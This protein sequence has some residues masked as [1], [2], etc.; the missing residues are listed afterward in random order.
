MCFKKGVFFIIFCNLL[1]AQEGEAFHAIKQ[2]YNPLYRVNDFDKM[3]FKVD[4]NSD[5]DNF[6]IHTINATNN[7]RNSLMPNQLLKLRLS[8]DYKFLG[9]FFSTSPSFLPGNE[10]NINKG[11]TKTL[12]LSFKFFF[13]DRLRQEVVYKRI[14]GFYFGTNSNT[15]PLDLFPELEI[16]TF[17]GKTFYIMNNNFSYRAFDNM[18]ERQLKS[19]GSLIPSIGYYYNVLATSE[20]KLGSDQLSEIHSIDGIFK[21]GYMYN[22]VIGKKWFATVGFHPGVGI[23]WSKNFYLP[24]NDTKNFEIKTT[25]F[26]L[27]TNSSLGYNNNNSFMGIKYYYS[28]YD[29]NKNNTVE[30]INSN[31]HFEVFLGYRF[32]ENKSIKKGFEVVENLL[33]I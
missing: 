3:I 12:D 32:K 9:M 14:K 17:G 10:N 25:N 15:L 28:D 23:N 5:I 20:K 29:F 18:T 27:T 24:P 8:F 26:N 11:K 33:K 19:T 2:N 7:S 4:V 16:K 1:F 21:I 22:F 30:L 13:S 31:S 6:Y